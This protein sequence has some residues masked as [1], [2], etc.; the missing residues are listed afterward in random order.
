MNAGFRLGYEGLINNIIEK[1]TSN[2]K[3]KYKII[4]TGGYAHFFKKMI[5]SRTII[6]QNITIKGIS[7]VYKELLIKNSYFFAHL[8]VLVR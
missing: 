8:E 1:I 2:R 4:L 6:D 7:R 5:K 3:I